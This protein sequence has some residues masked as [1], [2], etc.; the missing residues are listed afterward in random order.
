M[1]NPN[2]RLRLA[3]KGNGLHSPGVG[4]HVDTTVYIFLV[5]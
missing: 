2:L 4:L 1:S 3:V 5:C